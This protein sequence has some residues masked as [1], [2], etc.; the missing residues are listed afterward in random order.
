MG[1]GYTT[2][3]NC[4]FH[5]CS[6]VFNGG[7]IFVK[8]SSNLVVKNVVNIYR[9]IFSD[10]YADNGGALWAGN[11]DVFVH[12]TTF[13]NNTAN[14]DGGAIYAQNITVN[15]SIFD[16]N[17]AQAGGGVAG[18]KPL[19]GMRFTFCLFVSNVASTNGGALFFYQDQGQLTTSISLLSCMV[20]N[21]TAILGSGIYLQL[22]DPHDPDPLSV[23]SLD[24]SRTV[25]SG[26]NVFPGFKGGSAA[27]VTVVPGPSVQDFVIKGFTAKSNQ[28]ADVAC[29]SMYSARS[30]LF[31]PASPC[32]VTNCG[33]CDSACV[34]TFQS[35]EQGPIISST[36]GMFCLNGYTKQCNHGRCILTSPPVYTV[37]CACDSSYKGDSCGV[38]TCG[39][40][41]CL[42]WIPI[43][44]A[45]V[46]VV[47]ASVALVLRI[48]RNKTYAP[49]AEVPPVPASI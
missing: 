8:Q 10:N 42:F 5:G 32:E 11:D 38:Y 28:I 18:E 24:W 2:L 16:G 40:G 47:I 46:V 49:I 26:N 4:S 14:F 12:N 22:G 19:F 1:E 29:S 25:I 9:T 27:A 7:A 20:K 15:Q 30:F 45:V 39:I 35:S 6:S 3:D 23:F 21:N 13:V 17:S 34:Q 33:D 31:C 36:E 48:R 44:V 43:C 37:A 41:D